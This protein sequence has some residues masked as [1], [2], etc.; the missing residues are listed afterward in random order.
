MPHDTVQPLSA[1]FTALFVTLLFAGLVVKT[2][3]MRRQI[4]HVQARRDV[5]PAAFA[6]S[7]PL[8]SHQRAADYTA[9]RMRLA[10]SETAVGAL[11]VLALTLGGGLQAVHDAWAAIFEPGSL[12]H[13]IALLAALGVLGWLIDLPFV[14]VRTFVIEKRFGFN[15]MTPALFAADAARQAALAAV[16]GLPLLALLLWLTT[17][18]GALWWLWVW[19]FWLGFNLLVMLVWPTFIA[20]LFNKFTPLAD[21]V[22]KERAVA[23]PRHRR[24]RWSVPALPSGASTP[25]CGD[26]GNSW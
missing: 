6:A 22:L 10:M 11:F 2:A 12:A 5:V 25:S 20:P 21:A 17:A 23:P 15:R 8:G 16:L 18:M 26:P 24:C 13:G 7:I 3:L 14:L 1:A 19:A 9:A 4:R